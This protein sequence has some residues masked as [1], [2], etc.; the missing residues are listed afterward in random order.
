MVSNCRCVEAYMCVHSVEACMCILGGQGGSVIVARCGQ[1]AS[2][3]PERTLL[4]PTHLRERRRHPLPGPSP[5]VQRLLIFYQRP[6][7]HL[8]ARMY[9]LNLPFALPRCAA[10]AHSPLYPSPPTPTCGHAC[11]GPAFCPAPPPCSVRSFA[12]KLMPCDTSIDALYMQGG[13]MEDGEGDGTDE[14]NQVLIIR[15]MIC[16]QGSD[17]CLMDPAFIR[18]A[19]HCTSTAA[20]PTCWAHQ[21]ARQTKQAGY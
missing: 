3:A 19:A 11:A 14:G 2:M 4:P 1:P 16:A 7:P 18:A 5:A 21:G 20:C 17:K 9:A 10:P 15:C 8:W 12:K 13:R 6:P